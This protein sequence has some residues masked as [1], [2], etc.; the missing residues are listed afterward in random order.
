MNAP[1]RHVGEHLR[2][3]R[4][5]RRM[6]QMDL[7]LEA[8]IST[9]HLS[10]LETGRAQPSREMVLH[11]SDQLEIPL[12]ER[13]VILVAAGYAPVFPERNLDAPELASARR[14]VDLILKAHEPYPALVVDLRWNLVA[15]NAAALP[16]LDGVDPELLSPPLN[17]IRASL[18]PRGLAPRIAAG[19]PDA[20]ATRD[21][22][23]GQEPHQ[24]GLARPV[25]AEQGH[26]LAPRQHEVDPVEDRAAAV[27]EGEV[28]ELR[29]GI[30]HHAV[31]TA[32]LCGFPEEG[33]RCE[34][35]H[36]TGPAG[37]G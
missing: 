15:A 17:V 36:P 30:G 33:P 31:T 6:S 11:L 13:N 27:R 20:A 21:K 14:A 34:G 23:A 2:D 3:W 7:A 9:R 37:R 18:H 26:G 24:G 29:R 32:E 4:T 10:F 19:D 22:A 12:R 28:A 25:G 35:E 5:R 8:E 1:Q 16:L